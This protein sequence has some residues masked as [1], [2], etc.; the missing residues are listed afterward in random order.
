[1]Q[2]WLRNSCEHPSVPEMEESSVAGMNSGFTAVLQKELRKWR[3]Y[4]PSV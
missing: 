4:V 3:K 1:M 2:N